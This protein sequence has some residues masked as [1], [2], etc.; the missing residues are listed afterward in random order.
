MHVREMIPC[1]PL[2]VRGEALVRVLDMDLDADV[3]HMSAGE[4][5]R[6]QLLLHLMA[7]KPIVMLDEATSDLDVDQRHELLKFLYLE[8]EVRGVTIVYTTHIFEGLKGW[9]NSCIIL[10]RTTK[11]VHTVLHGEEVDLGKVTETLHQL[12][13]GETF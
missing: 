13:A 3:R 6:V 12:K 10:D 11:K 5:K 1:N 7:D 2:T 4:Q 9:A 8:S